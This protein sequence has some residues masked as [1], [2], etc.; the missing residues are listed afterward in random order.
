MT[1]GAG[2]WSKVLL[3]LGTTGVVSFTMATIATERFTRIAYTLAKP[4]KP[5][6][7]KM[8]LDLMNALVSS[9]EIY[10]KN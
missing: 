9:T 5:R 8:C 2:Q 10:V 7:P 3:L 4:K 1:L 6:I